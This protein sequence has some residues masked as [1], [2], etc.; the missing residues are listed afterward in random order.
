M[1]VPA[2]S[3]KHSLLQLFLQN[4]SS[5][6]IVLHKALWQGGAPQAG[7][8]PTNPAPSH[9]DTLTGGS[10]PAQTKEEICSGPD[11][12][13]QTSEATGKHEAYITLGLT[14]LNCSGKTRSLLTLGTAEERN[15]TVGLHRG[16]VR[17]GERKK[18]QKDTHKEE[19]I[20]GKSREKRNR[21][22]NNSI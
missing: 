5:P 13:T 12:T 14:Q 20:E 18:Q 16:V 17:G 15:K 3:K 19:E 2:L 10:P 6:Q 22:K 9:W 4:H 11:H 7:P 8:H 1:Q 21:R